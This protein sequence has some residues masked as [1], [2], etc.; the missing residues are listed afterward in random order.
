MLSVDKLVPF[1]PEIVIGYSIE[2]LIYCFFN[3][4]PF[5]YANSIIPH[6][7]DELEQNVIMEHFGI[8][9][10]NKVLTSPSGETKPKGVLK[11]DV[12]NKLSFVLSLNGLSI[13]PLCHSITIEGNSIKAL[14]GNARM[15]K[16]K[17]G[18]L[19]LFDDKNVF[20]LS[21]FS[22]KPN[23][24]YKVFDV[25]T[26]IKLTKHSFSF[27]KTNDSFVNEIKFVYGN[28]RKKIVSIS[29]IDEELLDDYEYSNIAVKFKVLWLLRE[30]NI[31]GIKVYS[32]YKHKQNKRRAVKMNT[33]TRE[34]FSMTLKN[35]YDSMDN[36]EFC[37]DTCETIFQTYGN[38]PTPLI[39]YIK[40][41]N[42][43]K[44]LCRNNTSQ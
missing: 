7:Y 31:K 39:K 13:M 35:K 26:S 11:R 36:I 20:G 34:T 9:N 15:A 12:F 27:I 40:K 1:Y 8:K 18:K 14:S 10:T 25:L 44:S 29:F 21:N 4:V 24:T 16:F 2:S 38:K 17:F 5:I 19:K 41:L 32:T 42:Y 23:V 43:A 3:N 30:N 22:Y 37:E 6:Q 33:E 28:G